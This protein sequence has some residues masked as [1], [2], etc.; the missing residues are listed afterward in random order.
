MIGDLTKY[1]GEIDRLRRALEFYA[2][3][4]N[5]ERVYLGF[6]PGFGDHHQPAAITDDLHGMRAREA[7]RQ[8]VKLGPAPAL[9]SPSLP[10]IGGGA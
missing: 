6:V 5:Y 8:P 10:A 1:L 2:D 7:L 3:P 9:S 4:K